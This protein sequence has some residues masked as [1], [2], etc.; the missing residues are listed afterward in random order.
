MHGIGQASTLLCKSCQLASNKAVMIL[1]RCLHKAGPCICF[2]I[3]DGN[4]DD[5]TM[6]IKWVR[7]LLVAQLVCAGTVPATN[8]ENK[9]VF[10]Q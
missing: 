3:L 5:E 4:A 8:T 2:A 1:L 6:A 9:L 10:C 7:K